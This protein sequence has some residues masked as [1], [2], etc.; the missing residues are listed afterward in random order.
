MSGPQAYDDKFAVG[1]YFVYYSTKTTEPQ[2]VCGKITK[3]DGEQWYFDF[4]DANDEWKLHNYFPM[5]PE[6]HR[7]HIQSPFY[8]EAF[9]VTKDEMERFSNLYKVLYA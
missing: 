3:F 9:V 8:Q 2:F 7:W 5:T 4:I 1:D 6:V